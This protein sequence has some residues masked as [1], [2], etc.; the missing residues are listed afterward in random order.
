MKRVWLLGLALPGILSAQQLPL[1][2]SPQPTRPAIDSADMMTRAYILADD[3]MQGR[4]PGT[5]G[6][7]RATSYIASE[8]ARL[9][10]VPGGDNGTY[11]QELPLKETAIGTPTLRAGDTELA[12]WTDFVPYFL[13]A[14]ANRFRPVD[15]VPVVFGGVVGDSAHWV[16][17][18]QARGKL[19]ILLMPKRPNGERQY[20]SATSLATLET[21]KQAAGVGAVSLDVAPV[22]LTRALRQTS[23]FMADGDSTPLPAVVL[24][25]MAGAAKLFDRPLD[26][27][28]AG[29]AGR[30]LH[31]DLGIQ[32]RSL[33]SRNVIGILPG[34]DPK[35]KG[36]VVAMGVHSDHVGMQSTPL[37]HDSIRAYN[38]ELERRGLQGP[39]RGMGSARSADIVINMDSL[40]KIRPARPDSIFNGADDDGS[41]ST[42]LLE[43]MEAFAT[44]RE[45]PRRTLL[46]I[47]HTGEE[48]GLLGSA[49]HTTHTAV[50][51][52][53]IVAYLNQD[54]VGRGM[55]SDITGGGPRYLQLI[56]PRRL[57]TELGDIIEAVNKTEKEP[58]E[59]DYSYDA[60]G[61]PYNR[62]CRSDH[63]MYARFG[64]PVTQFS[65]GYHIDYHQ[66][67]DE[68]QYLNYPHL[69][70][71]AQ[72]VHDVAERVANLDHRLVVDQ[73]KPDPTTACRQ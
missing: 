7:T 50:P 12:P 27:L 43:I 49:Y 8:L 45:R 10:L 30:T 70:R 71:I 39:A 28:A 2:H 13:R 44:A 56:G 55:A 57:S 4:G 29:D 15:G 64:I 37:D 47:W 23:G 72:L 63:A 67:T 16:T 26:S 62:Y 18:E 11:F 31:G 36:Q 65:A 54:M 58:M 21:F 41:G 5:A 14:A 25:S 9:K 32:V 60:N 51:R 34:S 59:L 6:A 66:L 22:N 73:P 53:S 19:V 35:L 69:A 46:F 33:G 20:V 48:M 61:H 52:D 24:F 1:K 38:T 42:S 17:A 40:R 3:S 68:P